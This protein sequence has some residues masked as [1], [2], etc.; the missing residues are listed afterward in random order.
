MLKRRTFLKAGAITPLSPL[1]ATL[2]TSS[3]VLSGCSGDSV[4]SNRY[5]Q[6]NFAPVEQESTITQLQVTGTI[7]AEL[8]GRFLRNG[9]NPIS[10]ETDGD[11]HWFTGAGMVHGLSL[12]EGS[13]QWYRNRFVGGSGANT[14]VIGHAGQTM[15]I[16]ESGGMA[17]NL[18]YTLESTGDNTAIGGG[19]SAHPKLDP[20]TGELH[21]MCYDWANLRD[22]VRYV[23]IDAD[24]EWAD[25][26]EIPLPGMP[27]IHDMSLTQ[28]YAIIYDLPVTLSFMALGTGANFPFRWDAEY[29][30]RVGLIPRNGSGQDIIWKSVNPN[31]AYHPMNA[32]EDLDGNVVI[33]IVRYE[34][35]FKDDIR[36]PFGDSNPRLDR[37]TIN[38]GAANPKVS[39]VIV[40]ARG[41]EFPRCHPDLNGKPYQYGYTVAVEDYGF[42]SIY[43]HDLKSGTVSQFDVGPGRHSAEP[44]FIPKDGAQN[45]DEGYLITYVYDEG[46]NASDLLILDAQDMSRPALAQVHLPVRVPYGFHGNWVA[47]A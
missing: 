13:A 18:N 26:I 29:E 44:V 16:V 19:F 37:W 28:N 25:E 1:L 40:D 36:G 14:N 15:A 10:G 22:H 42:P 45:E 8:N 11:Y 6:A 3:F 39:E 46:K 17:Q 35:M 32:Y 27:M 5:L 43:K 30:P 4:A 33:D 47:D 12:Q 21:A 20:D 9:P 31:Y 41:Q 2:G 23:V 24:G 34:S 7:P 38:P